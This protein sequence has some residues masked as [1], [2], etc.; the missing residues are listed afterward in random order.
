MARATIAWLM[1]AF[2]WTKS[3]GPK[4]SLQVE[5]IEPVVQVDRAGRQRHDGVEP[6][7]LQQDAQA[8]RP[9]EL[10]QLVEIGLGQR[11]QH[12][13]TSTRSPSDSATSICGMLDAARHAGEQVRQRADQRRDGLGQ[14]LTT[15]HVS[16]VL[17]LLLAKADETPALLRDEARRQPRA[18]AVVPVWP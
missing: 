10:A 3:V 7:G 15:L 13:Q 2:T 18:P 17:A 11:I 6:A 9:L 1:A 16:D 14:H 12:A 4:S 5:V 8:V